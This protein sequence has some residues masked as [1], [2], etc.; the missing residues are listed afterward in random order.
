MNPEGYPHIWATIG[1]LEDF[2]R[3]DLHISK[4][5]FSIGA[6]YIMRL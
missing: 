4:N 1:Y 3:A 5:S 6:V 2:V